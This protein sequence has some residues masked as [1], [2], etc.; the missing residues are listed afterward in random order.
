MAIGITRNSNSPVSTIK[1]SQAGNKAAKSG[2]QATGKSSSAGSSAKSDSV[3]LTA[4]ATQLQ[5]LENRIA[6]MPVV[7][8]TIV[9][10]VQQQLSTGSFEVNEKSTANK[11][12][13]SEKELASSD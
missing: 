6:S 1:K 2:T 3:N 8:V 11:L 9:D 4:S 13:D 5:D 12:L 10:S 7:D